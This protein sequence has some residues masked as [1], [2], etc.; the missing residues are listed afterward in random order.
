MHPCKHTGYL[1]E[2]IKNRLL[3]KQKKLHQGDTAYLR[4]IIK[5]YR[6]QLHGKTIKD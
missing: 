6:I 1:I 2:N 5:S 3:V 4:E